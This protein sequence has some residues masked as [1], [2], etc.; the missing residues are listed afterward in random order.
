[1]TYFLSKYIFERFS[2]SF[3]L[4]LV[5]EEREVREVG[6]RAPQPGLRLDQAD[7]AR[8]HPVLAPGPGG[9]WKGTVSERNVREA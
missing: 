2:R 7:V 3:V 4:L 5:A 9:F 1:M 6:Q 8:Q